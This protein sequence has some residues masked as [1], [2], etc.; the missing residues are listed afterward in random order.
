MRQVAAY[1]F[2][3]LASY[4]FTAD[5]NCEWFE[6]LLGSELVPGFNVFNASIPPC[7]REILASGGFKKIEDNLNS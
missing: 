2:N 5:T 1:I 3:Q 4:S 6:T 7:H